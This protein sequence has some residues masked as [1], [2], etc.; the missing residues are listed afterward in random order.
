MS[1]YFSG[2]EKDEGGISTSEFSK[3]LESRVDTVASFLSNLNFD[4]EGNIIIGSDTNQI[5]I[6]HAD[7][8]FQRMASEY[9]YYNASPEYILNI[10]EKY[11]TP[12]WKLTTLNRSDENEDIA[13]VSIPLFK[14]DILTSM[15]FYYRYTDY[16]Y[17]TFITINDIQNTI[18]QL[19]ESPS[20][21]N[22]WIFTI[23]K[24]QLIEFFYSG[25]LNG[26][27]NTWLENAVVRI[28]SEK[29]IQARQL[30]P[31][32]Y[33]CY[34]EFPNGDIFLVTGIAWV[35][36]S[37]GYYKGIKHEKAGGFGFYYYWGK[38]RGDTGDNENDA[39]G[40][41]NGDNGD[42][43]GDGDGDGEKKTIKKL[44]QVD[45]ATKILG[46][47]GL[48]KIESMI[49][50]NSLADPCN[51]SKSTKDI[52]REAIE[53]KCENDGADNLGT[54][55]DLMKDIG[56]N[57]GG[58][59]NKTKSFLACKSL[60]CLFDELYYGGVT[61]FCELQNNFE[62]DNKI[63]DLKIGTSDQFTKGGKGF[64]G[65]NPETGRITIWFNPN[66]CVD[67]FDYNGEDPFSDFLR[68]SKT[69]IHES[70]HAD[71]WR[72]INNLLPDGKNLTNVDQSTFDETFREFIDII[73]TEGDNMSDQHEAMMRSE[74]HKWIDKLAQDLWELNGEV[75]NWEDYLYLAWLGIY[76]DKS[77]ECLNSFLTEDEY[78]VLKD[79]YEQNIRKNT[80]TIAKMNE[81]NNCISN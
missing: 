20:F 73:C 5:V 41:G 78:G 65:V 70:I 59:M 53:E 4:E 39:G 77:D 44:N 27:Y 37:G 28:Q 14:D 10:R 45:C 66:M 43:G 48:S 40:N 54:I 12:N 19:R 17:A 23:A 71:F 11:G 75:G 25:K 72:E 68:S 35:P 21:Y 80:I 8:E 29:S 56:D 36:C 22:E 7:I 51:P 24:F 76:T 67:K 64:T 31:E 26:T 49:A 50:N 9:L 58:K 6:K 33:Y 30:C 34:V 15:I 69:I 61:N 60:N 32:T 79:N 57:G 81:I 62:T 46:F 16:E 52:I 38:K 2:C 18:T 3:K 1:V 47:M 74:A 42:N 63:I 55:E 13:I